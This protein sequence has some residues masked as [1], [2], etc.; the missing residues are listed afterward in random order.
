MLVV[1]DRSPSS[2]RADFAALTSLLV[3]TGPPGAGKSTIARAVAD[4]A[5]HRVLVEGDAFF[6][7]LASGR[8]DPWMPARKSRTAWSSTQRPRRP[9]GSYP[10]GIR[11]STTGLSALVPTEVR[12]GDRPRRDPLPD[13]APVGRQLCAAGGD[14]NRSRLH[15]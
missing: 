15:G 6:G 1:P 14:P 7:F 3:F 11:P 13:L 9:V 8:I 2:G 12:A 4:Q 5:D 10:V